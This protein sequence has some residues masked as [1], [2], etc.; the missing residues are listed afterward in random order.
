MLGHKVAPILGDPGAVSG[1]KRRIYP[2]RNRSDE[3][4]FVA[5]ISARFI[6]SFRPANCPW[7]SE[8]ELPLAYKRLQNFRFCQAIILLFLT[9]KL[10]N[11]YQFL[12]ALVS[13]IDGFSL[14]RQYQK[15][16]KPRKG[17]FLA[18]KSWILSFVLLI[19]WDH[20]WSSQ[21]LFLSWS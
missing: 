15:V 4:F 10:S 2:G 6:P 20:Y 11:F 7:V 3:S 16:K 12:D 13:S 8:D 1:A 5:T 18:S 14:H 9:L 17:N 21:K 19:V